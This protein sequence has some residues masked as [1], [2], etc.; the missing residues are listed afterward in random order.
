MRV[1]CEAEYG[2]NVSEKN[3]GEAGV[4]EWRLSFRSAQEIGIVCLP[5]GLL[6]GL[7]TLLHR[8]RM[9]GWGMCG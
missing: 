1:V 7:L 4:P 5:A 3:L 8:I 9:C 6:K 2:A